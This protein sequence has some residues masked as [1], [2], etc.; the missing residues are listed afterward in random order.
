MGRLKIAFAQRIPFHELGSSTALCRSRPGKSNL[1]SDI[2]SLS[3]TRTS[4]PAVN[5]FYPL[6]AT[7]PRKPTSIALAPD[8]YTLFRV[9]RPELSIF[10]SSTL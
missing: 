10:Y 7:F 2:C 4:D 9:P 6:G 3:S 8:S 1:S 5:T